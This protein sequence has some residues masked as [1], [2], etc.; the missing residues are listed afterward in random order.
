MA[1][2]VKN[3][4]TRSLSVLIFVIVL[5]SSVLFNYVS[6]TLFFLLVAM[7]GL[8]EFFKISVKLGAKP[9]KALGYICA[10]LLYISFIDFSIFQG[11]DFFNS[12]NHFK[13]W[14]ICIPFIILCRAIFDHSPNSILNALYTI[15]G[16]IYA[17][18]PF[19]LLI[20]IVGWQGEGSHHQFNPHLVLGS[21]FLIWANDTFA[22]L[23]G[24]LFGKHK[25]I[26]GIQIIH[27]LK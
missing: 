13:A 8:N 14:M 21:I 3:L 15:M 25:M 12:F 20:Q 2:N 16:L 17:V 26:N 11:A 10:C 9:Y 1:L 5:L 6:F 4:I 22:Y 19:V 18:L 24:S 23:G 27:A 7:I